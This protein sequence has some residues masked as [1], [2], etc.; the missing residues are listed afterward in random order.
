MSRGFNF[1][2]PFKAQQLT[3]ERDD[4]RI[5][6]IVKIHKAALAT[7]L[8]FSTAAFAVENEQTT[9]QAIEKQKIEVIEVSA[10]R[11]S[12]KKSLNTKRFSDAIVDAISAEDVGKFPDQT[13]AD[14]L[15]RIP[16][17]SIEKDSGEGNKVSIR[18]TSPH[19]NLTLINGFGPSN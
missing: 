10:Y 8:I 11:G 12:L 9:N 17:V 7:S 1:I 18:G 2:G 5:I 3:G 4:Y 16:G 19:L 6:T 13:V 15:Q 14:S